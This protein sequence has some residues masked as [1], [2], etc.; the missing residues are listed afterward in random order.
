MDD[1]VLTIAKDVSN[2]LRNLGTL[3]KEVTETVRVIRKKI[4]DIPVPKH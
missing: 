3:V 2:L 4:E 1:L